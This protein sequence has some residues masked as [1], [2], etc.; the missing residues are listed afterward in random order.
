MQG[1]KMEHSTIFK[2]E[3]R[4]R[5]YS[6]DDFQDLETTFN[7]LGAARFKGKHLPEVGGVTEFWLVVEFI[8]LSAVAGIIGHIA[9]QFYEKLS[10]GLL[11]FIER[12]RKQDPEYP[13][14]MSLKLSYDDLDI[15]ISLPEEQT[16]GKLSQIVSE[17]HAHLATFPLSESAIEYVALLVEQIDGRWELL[18]IWN[19]RNYTLRFWGVGTCAAP[20]ITDVYDAQERGL[21]KVTPDKLPRQCLL[22]RTQHGI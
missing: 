13:E 12:K 7:S 20:F 6:G 17:I 16:I 2:A 11:K 5:G 4:A 15:F 3:Y 9:E 18:S 22:D 10:S 8:G 14:F 19:H 1:T 21:L